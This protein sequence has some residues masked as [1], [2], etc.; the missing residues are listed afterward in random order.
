MTWQSKPFGTSLPRDEALIET[1]ERAMAIPE[2]PDKPRLGAATRLDMVNVLGWLGSRDAGG[3]QRS[4]APRFGTRLFAQVWV[5]NVAYAK[6]V[7]ADV[8]LL[9]GA[10]D[11]L[12]AQT[13]G[14]QY[15]EPADGDGDSF[16]LD[17]WVPSSGLGS[18]A[19]EA[20]RLQFRIYY[21]V[22]GTLFTD[23]FV[24]DHELI[25]PDRAAATGRPGEARTVSKRRSLIISNLLLAQAA[26][27]SRRRF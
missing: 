26:A 18:R 16:G 11:V 3:A 2:L 15:L 23:G 6:D 7:W 27:R 1:F 10:R 4:P 5:N 14:F 13:F 20:R 25:L 21:E 22:E 12:Y 9:D 19:G 17:V 8:Y 24:H